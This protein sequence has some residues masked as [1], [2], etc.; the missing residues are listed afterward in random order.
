MYEITSNVYE[1]IVSHLFTKELSSP[2]LSFN[3]FFVFLRHK[4]EQDNENY[5]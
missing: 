2:V 3:F 4:N 5:K 1:T